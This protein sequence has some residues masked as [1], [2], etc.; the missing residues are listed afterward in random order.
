MYHHNYYKDN[1]FKNQEYYSNIQ[2]SVK[3]LLICLN[4]SVSIDI[5]CDSIVDIVGV[6]IHQYEDLETFMQEA[7]FYDDVITW[8]SKNYT[9]K[10]FN[11]LARYASEGG[12]KNFSTALLRVLAR[13]TPEK[14]WQRDA[15]LQLE[16]MP[17]ATQISTAIQVQ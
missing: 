14:Y 12:Y 6:F 17:A 4:N 11:I 15:V 1:N 16:H 13:Y 8:G 3:V 7:S 9:W 10:S 5:L 2:F